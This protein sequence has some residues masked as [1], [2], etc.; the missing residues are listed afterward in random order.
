MGARG[1]EGGD[2][3]RVVY[4]CIRKYAKHAGSRVFP[5]VVTQDTSGCCTVGGC[6]Q[7]GGPGQ[8]VIFL[9]YLS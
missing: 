2:V 3:Q 5:E 6:I 9:L 1:E 8:A 4:V 7:Y